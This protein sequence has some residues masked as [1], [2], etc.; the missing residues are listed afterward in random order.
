MLW[1]ALYFPDLSL[2]AVNRAFFFERDQNDAAQRDGVLVHT[3]PFVVTDGVESRPILYA[4]NAAAHNVGLRVGMT[5]ASARAMD[6]SLMVLPRQQEK[7]CASLRSIATWLA[8]FTPSVSIES[9]ID[10]ASVNLEIASS[11]RLFGGVQPMVKRIRSGMKVLGYRALIGIA[12]NALAAQL[13]ARATQHMPNLRMCERPEQLHERLA[14]IPVTHFRWPEKTLSALQTLGLFRIKDVLLQPRAGLQKR[15]GEQLVTDLDRAL[16]ITA[17]PRDYFQLPDQFESNIEFLFEINST[18]L[19]L[20]PI[21]QLF[22]EMEGFL[23][24]RGAGVMALRISLKHGRE[25]YTHLDF[26]ARQSIR[27]TNQW[28][29]L[30]RERLDATT[31]EA[32]VVLA[33]VAA[34]SLHTFSEENENLIPAISQSTTKSIALIDRLASRLGAKNVYRIAARNDHRPEQAWHI[35]DLKLHSVTSETHH[36]ARPS[37]LLRE[38]RS[39]VT[40]DECPQYQGA[41]VLLAGP[42]RIDTGWWDGKPVARDYF[43]ARNPH[44]EVCWI[45]RDYRQGRRWYLHGF[46]S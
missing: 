26:K 44:H 27:D 21:T 30:V 13:L 37:W 8:Q 23:R 10:C 29:R 1:I 9:D 24:A 28:L 11:L 14:A 40:V 43:V 3:L 16:G 17:D 36:T 22:A 45:F 12:P 15:F 39:L 5:L 18:D 20:H 25:H 34:T 38:P 2:E 42:E 46:F 19:L 31:L 6:S 7:E 33:A 41:L 32:P 4:I 35:N